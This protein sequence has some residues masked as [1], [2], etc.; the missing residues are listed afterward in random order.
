MVLLFVLVVRA[1]HPL[2]HARPVL[3]QVGVRWHIGKTKHVVGAPNRAERLRA[4]Y[5]DIR[6]NPVG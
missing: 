6:I 2:L 3:L 1:Q 4:V 5:H